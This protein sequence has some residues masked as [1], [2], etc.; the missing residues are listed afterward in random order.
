MPRDTLFCKDIK[1]SRGNWVD[2][3]DGSKTFQCGS[4]PLFCIFKTW[5]DCLFEKNKWKKKVKITHVLSLTV[6]WQGRTIFNISERSEKSFSQVQL[7]AT[8]WTVYSPGQNTGVGS[9]SLLQ[10]ILQTQGLNPGLSCCRWVL[11]QLI[12]KGSPRTLKW[13]ACPFASGCS[14]PRN[15]TGV[16][17]IADR[18]FTNWATREAHLTLK[19]QFAP[20]SHK[21]T[22]NP[23]TKAWQ[24]QGKRNHRP[25]LLLNRDV[26]IVNKMLANHNQ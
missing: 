21:L 8:P 23:D 16:S 13:V 26:K 24:V 17:C 18:S 25:V 7:F 5:R 2:E 22:Y 11:Y 3:M 14:R 10:G 9:L 4:I 1:D 6:L 20:V 19:E 12:H 15:W